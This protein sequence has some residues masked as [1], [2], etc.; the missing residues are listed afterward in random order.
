MKR[1][2]LYLLYFVAVILCLS[3]IV[4][5]LWNIILP[6]VTHL[7][8]INYWQALALTV[9]CRILFGRLSLGASLVKYRGEG[10]A[11]ILKDKLMTMDEADKAAFKE[12]WRRR[13]GR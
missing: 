2:L 4:M 13:C 12:E 11:D 7:A 10:R 5:F 6:Q 8:K 9:L 3:G 1:K